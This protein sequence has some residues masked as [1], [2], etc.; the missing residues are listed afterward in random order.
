MI[1]GISLKSLRLSVREEER[2]L[3]T[4]ATW[5]PPDRKETR[6]P[7]AWQRSCEKTGGVR[8]VQG[9]G[10]VNGDHKKLCCNTLSY[11]L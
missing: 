11:S 8:R 9:V 2:S 3:H 1:C 10:D 4:A 5:E 7:R 6:K